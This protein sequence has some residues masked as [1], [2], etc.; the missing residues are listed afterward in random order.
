MEEEIK[1]EYIIL[2][3]V[4]DLEEAM[5]LAKNSG[6]T[7][8]VI[9][10]ME[11]VH[12]DL[13]ELGPLLKSEANYK[14]LKADVGGLVEDLVKNSREG[15]EGLT[16]GNMRQLRDKVRMLKTVLQKKEG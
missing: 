3:Y 1:E 11:S 13:V 12:D 6:I 8:G 14:R 7:E 16:L 15:N 2:G 10:G 9:K 4:D 5:R